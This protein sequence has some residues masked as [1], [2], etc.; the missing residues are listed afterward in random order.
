MRNL[1]KEGAGHGRRDFWGSPIVG[2]MIFCEGSDYEAIVSLVRQ[3]ALERGLL[4]YGCSPLPARLFL[5]CTTP[6]Q[7]GGPRG[8]RVPKE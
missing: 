1:I 6:L 7:L 8:R 5:H 2:W 3:R 4:S